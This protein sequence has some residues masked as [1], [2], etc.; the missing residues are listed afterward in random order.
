M[1]WVPLIIIVL[2]IGIP[3]LVFIWVF[4][5]FRGAMGGPGG[6]MGGLGGL[7]GNIKNGLPADAV[8][9][10]IQETGM[11]ITSPSAGP[12]AAVYRFGLQVT[13]QGGP[14]Y[15]A[16]T[17]QVVPRVYVPMMVPGAQIGVMVDAANPA[18]VAVDWSRFG[19]AAPGAAPGLAAMLPEAPPSTPM[20]AG[21][22]MTT[23]G[24]PVTFDAAGNPTS[25]LA[26]LVGAVQS[27]KVPTIRG[28]AAELLATGTHG[29]AVITTAQPL[30]MKVRDINPAA[31][32]SHLDDP[33][34]LFT[35]EVTLPG[36]QPFTSMFGHRV[37]I[38]K[39]P[40]V[41]PGVRLA[42]AVDESNP[43]AECA[44]DWDRSPLP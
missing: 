32:P 30:G 3:L 16:E 36:R 33:M 19:A 11:T 24:V 27:H 13:P 26:D 25:G 28:K 7:S 43:S 20:T 12:E 41:A 23:A 34:W 4:R 38:A 39:V 17:T 8:I 42:V 5:Q 22:V 31:E 21:G 18:H 29:T 10:S 44:I 9:S 14:P 1:D 40:D 35:L 15:E 2:S 6:L 37:P